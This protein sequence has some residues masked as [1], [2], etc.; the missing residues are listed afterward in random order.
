MNRRA[1]IITNPGEEG[2]ENYCEGVNRDAIN[3]RAFLKSPIGGYWQE[4]EIDNMMR[5]RFRDVHEKMQE[6]LS[7]DYVMVIFSGHGW[8][9]KPLASTILELR[10]DQE[11]D[12]AE[13]RRARGKETLILDCCRVAHAGIPSVVEMVEKYAMAGAAIHAEACRRFY[14]EWI[15]KCASELVVMYACS[16]GQKAGDDDEM[17]GVYSHCLLAGARDWAQNVDGDTSKN[18]YILSVVQ[19]HELAVEC[20]HRIRGDRQ[21]PHIEKPRTGPYFPFCIVA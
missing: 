16:T 10:K 20:V 21:S 11:I 4:G 8:Y 17:G 6:L 7:C 15:G 5:P 12:S 3:Y 13:L 9:S 1:I 19:A 14:D 2:A 18:Y